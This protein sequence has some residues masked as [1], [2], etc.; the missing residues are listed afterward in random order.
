[1]TD[2]LQVPFNDLKP[3]V[4]AHRAAIDRAIA[5]VLDRGYFILGPE[6]DAFEKELA[7]VMG[8]CDAVAVANG[9]DALLL[10]LEV[11]GVGP[12]DEV[13]T[14]PM[15]AAFSALAVSRLGAI[16]VFGD[17]DPK[18]MNLDPATIEARITSRTRAILP[19]HLYGHPAD[20]DPIME[21]ARRHNLRVVEDAC[22]AH[23]AR[24]KGRPVGSI[25]GIAG[26]S[27]YPTKNLGGFGDGGAILVDD[28]ALARRLR[29]LRNGGQ[30]EKYK[31]DIIGTNSRLD[32]M[33]AAILRELLQTLDA[34]TTRRREIAERYFEAFAGL[35]LGLPEEQEYARAVYHLFVVRHPRRQAF[36][37]ALAKR[38]VGT[39]IHYPIA[40][41]LQAAYA[42]LGGRPGDRPVV[43]RAAEEIVSL[44]V[45]PELT[46]AQVGAVIAAVKE[47]VHA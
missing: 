42:F 1:M 41:H 31:H 47:S 23:S 32:D 33:Q 27:F 9:T 45:Y 40:L 15:S 7:A 24:Y 3:K 22:Q 10:A 14:S 8:M 16:P 4:A 11:T 13:I 38:G 46:D 21:I 43:E 5:R 39:L 25:A 12:G 18:T 36:M 26:L 20:L 34:E 28:P 44:P 35:P 29:Q 19:V 6:V 17:I 37:S 2:T 30:S